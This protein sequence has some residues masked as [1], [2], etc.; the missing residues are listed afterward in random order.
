MSTN[1]VLDR[2]EAEDIHVFRLMHSLYPDKYPPVDWPH[3]CHAAWS[4]CMIE[5][6]HLKVWRWVK[7]VASDPI[8][9]VQYG[10]EQIRR[11]VQ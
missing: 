5:Q 2:Y 11:E 4:G 3:K 8:G 1:P 9:Y 10:I 6:R 7:Q